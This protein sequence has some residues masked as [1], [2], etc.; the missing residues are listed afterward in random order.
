MGITKTEKITV[1]RVFWRI[2]GFCN[3]HNFSMEDLRKGADPSFCSEFSALEDG[4]VEKL[5]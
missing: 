4:S 3:A 5:I 2:F 1:F